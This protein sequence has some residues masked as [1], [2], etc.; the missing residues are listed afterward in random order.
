MLLSNQITFF[1]ARH[2]NSG[3]P[4]AQI[5]L[6]KALQRR[7]YKVDYVIGY[8]PE[9]LSIPVVQGVNVIS[10]NVSRAHKLIL[11]ILSYLRKTRPDVIFT[12]EDHLNV[13]VAL[14]VILSGSR[15]KLSASSR[16]TPYDTYSSKLLSKRWVL[17]KLHPSNY[18]S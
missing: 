14:A 11:P 17:K 4:L 3:V 15:A 9:D 2:S 8:V 6:A 1:T 12:A 7:G 5:R 16:V 10:L 13:I 18:H